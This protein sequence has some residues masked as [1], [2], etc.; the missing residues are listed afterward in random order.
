MEWNTF[1]LNEVCDVIT[2]GVAKR[3][4]YV[5]KGIPFL[6]SKNVKEYKFILKD[7]NYIS[8]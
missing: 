2:C 3:P 6:S 1:N 7:Y 5:E 8:N 4:E